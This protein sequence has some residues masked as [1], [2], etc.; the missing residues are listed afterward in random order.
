MSKFDSGDTMFGKIQKYRTLVSNFTYLSVLYGFNLLIPFITFPY[1]IYVLGKETYGLVVFAQ[2]I[3]TYLAVFVEFGFDLYAT[4]EISIFRGNKQKLS[5]IVNSVL[6]IKGTL[7]IISF[8]FLWLI[9]YTFPIANQHKVLFVFSM[10][11]CVNQ[12]IFPRWYFLGIEEMKY[13]TLVNLINRII[14]VSLI[15]LL[16]NKES[17]YIIVPLLHGIGAIIG[18]AYALWVI[19]VKDKI[20]LRWQKF[21]ILKHYSI[22]SLPLFVSNFSVQIYSHTNKIIVGSFLGMTEVTYYNIAERIVGL[23]NTPLILIIRTIYPKISQGEDNHFVKRMF[24]LSMYITLGICAFTLL[25][26]D[27]FIFLFEYI[28]DKTFPLAANVVRI[29]ILALPF[30]T[31]NS[32]FGTQL[33]IQDRY[34]QKFMWSIITAALLYFPMILILYMTSNLTIYSIP[35]ITVF[36]QVYIAA[37]TYILV[38]KYNLF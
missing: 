26:A 15:F 21:S 23:L 11:V 35:L 1:L 12:W 4:K 17:D 29:L 3:I 19:F 16:V 28:T 32:Y 31:M 7:C 25:G 18:G 13:I 36:A 27:Y 20:K 2:A 9:L 37:H 30:I 8:F 22:Q 34:R 14:A 5:E 33:L 10:F 38:K 24:A 6:I